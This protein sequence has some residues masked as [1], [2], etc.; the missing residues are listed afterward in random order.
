[1]RAL[2]TLLCI[3]VVIIVLLA[4][5]RGWRARSARDE[6]HGASAAPSGEIIARFERGTAELR[7]PQYVS[8]TPAGDPLDRVAIPGLRY[9]GRSEVTVR[10]DGVTIEVDGEDPVHLSAAQIVGASSAGRR[11]GKAVEDGGLGLLV[12]R[13]ETPL[14]D[15]AAR[16]LESSFR[17]STREEQARFR[18]AISELVQQTEHPQEGTR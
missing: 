10:Q 17:F 1:M 8:T 11:V 9:R 5:W 3:A 13:L 2:L 6:W 16:T 14:D 18:A 12:W 15:G 4:M 7:G